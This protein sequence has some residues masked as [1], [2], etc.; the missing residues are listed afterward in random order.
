MEDEECMYDKYGFC[1]FK[2]HCQRKHY[3]VKYEDSAGCKGAKVC[4]KRHPKV[5]KRFNSDK[6]CQFGSECAYNHTDS[7]KSKGPTNELQKKVEVLETI[8][9]EM[10]KEVI[11]LEAELKDIKS[12]QSQ[13]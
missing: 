9:I 2:E 13:S 5:C 12:V 3:K 11:K 8:V 1:K 7:I 6:G 10:A 4:Q